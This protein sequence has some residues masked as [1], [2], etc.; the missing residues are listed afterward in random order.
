MPKF[1]LG[2]S[3]SPRYQKEVTMGASER[4]IL[5]VK[6][7]EKH[8]RAVSGLY[9][10][11]AQRFPQHAAAWRKLAYAEIEHAEWLHN[12]EAGITDGSLQFPG[13]KRL[14]PEVVEASLNYIAEEVASVRKSER[15][16]RDALII[17]IGIEQTMLEGEWFTLFSGD[18]PVI[19]RVLADLA[20]Q[21]RQHVAD[22]QQ[23]LET[24]N[25]AEP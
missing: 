14:L 6:L 25:V 23:L 8:E 7:L 12:L 11:Y 13:A 21:T 24:E 1:D 16:L 22:L 9:K 20:A 3:G 5:L 18:S 19:Q 15:P 10:N 2:N 17:A 4:E